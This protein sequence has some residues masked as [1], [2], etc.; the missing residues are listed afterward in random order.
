M[1]VQITMAKGGE[2]REGITLKEFF[3]RSNLRVAA[4][5]ECRPVDNKGRSEWSQVSLSTA[6]EM[7]SVY[8]FTLKFTAFD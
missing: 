3:I 7:V 4:G 8:I 2:G 5:M 6:E 1:K